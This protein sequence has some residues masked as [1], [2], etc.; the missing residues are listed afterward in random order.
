VN[1]KLLNPGRFIAGAGFEGRELTFTIAKVGREVLEG[2]GNAKK[3]KGTITL[4]ELHPD[5]GEPLQWLL[6]VT[7]ATSL[8]TM[9]GEE[10]DAW[11]GKAVTLGPEQVK[12]NGALE[13]GIRVRG[14]PD[15]PRDM[16]YSLRLPRKKAVTVQL[17]RTGGPPPT[18]ARGSAPARG[19]GPARQ[20][21][22]PR[23]HP[24][25]DPP[26]EELMRGYPGEPGSDG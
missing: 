24:A 5:T 9:F 17:R 13:I 25:D 15:I 19:Q 2:E 6:N 3:I 18:P 4:Q 12:V 11:V 8:M 22:P 26:M 16:Q 23:T 10:T 14:S 7:N 21:P 20:A 1:W